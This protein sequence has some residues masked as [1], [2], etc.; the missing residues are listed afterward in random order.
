MA[1]VK[2]YSMRCDNR[3]QGKR[4]IIKARCWPKKIVVC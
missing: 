1:R 2:Y 3:M 4:Y